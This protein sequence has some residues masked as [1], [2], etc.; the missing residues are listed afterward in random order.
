MTQRMTS[1]GRLLAAGA[2]LI[3]AAAPASAQP[4]APV[5]RTV[6]ASFQDGRWLAA[7]DTIE[8]TFPELPASPGS[9]PAILIGD[10]DWT[11][12]FETAGAVMRY[13]PGAIPLPS[14][15]SSVV[16]YQIGT[17]GGVWNE[18]ARFTLRVLNAAGFE[19]AALEPSASINLAGQAAIDPAPADNA[20]ERYQDVTYTL[21]WLST[22]VRSGWTTT[23]QINT[24]GAGRREQALR[25]GTLAAEAPLLDLSDYVVAFEHTRGRVAAGH[26][27]WDAHPHLVSQF[28]TRGLAARVRIGPAVD[29]AWHAMN[30]TNLV[31]WTNPTGL[32]RRT[33]QVVGGSVGVE[34]WPVRPG[35]ARLSATWVDASVLPLSGFT[36]ALVNDAEKSRGMGLRF[37][38][39]DAA[40]RL[41]IDG[42]FA[43]SR[44][45][46]P[47]DSLLS[48][49]T[50]VVPTRETSR[51]A[52]YLDLSYA[53]L[54][55][56]TGSLSAA[57]R[58]SRI[59]PL[60]KSITA[61]AQADLLENVVAIT[62]GLRQAIS[63]F[64]FTVSHDDLD[65]LP[66]LMRTSTRLAAWR[67]A[68][69]LASFNAR[70]PALPVVSFAF[71]R[72][73]QFGNGLP[74]NSLF[75]SASQVPDQITTSQTLGAE[76]QPGTA[77]LT[78]EWNRSLQDNR[79]PGRESADFETVAH[80]FGAGVMSTSA[81]DVGAEVSFEGIDALEQRTHD[82]TRRLGINAT[83]RP[84]RT[85]SIGGSLSRTFSGNDPRTRKGRSS[86]FTLQLTQD[87]VFAPRSPNR[88][89][90]QGFVRFARR[91]NRLTDLE[92]GADSQDQ[93]WVLNTGLTFRIF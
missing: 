62:G 86:D 70:A 79:Q 10:T 48:Q 30:G 3:L 54:P 90:G 47:E 59:D 85:T 9:R 17:P 51:N 22:L 35:A 46:N 1:F 26:V 31:G 16:V 71:N 38:G 76:W 93:S 56:G 32:D 44:F 57:F 63:E 36:E 33:H 18:V 60:Y 45:T 43:R 7:R 4:R 49:G 87:V 53:I 19:R 89:R 11:D 58:H 92:F 13:A 66:S 34:M 2:A 69:P 72:M 55:Q 82:T 6:T 80:A 64:T 29:V 50:L 77:R 42:G 12:L 83:W 28:A 24:V 61:P 39:S 52:R 91:T 67:S 14:G 25:Y 5:A 88:L 74:G 23:T 21:G 41:A 68:V 20:R 37:I 8:V 15:E 81:L 27:S 40:R 65:D 73:H 78:Y 84:G 75:D